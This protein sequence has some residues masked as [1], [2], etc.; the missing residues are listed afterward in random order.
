MKKLILFLVM[1]F[2]IIPVFAGNQ[3][4]AEIDIS[5]YFI[6]LSYF[7][8]AILIVTQFLLKYIKTQ[9]DQLV[10]WVVSFALAGAGWLLELG[11]FIGVEWYWAIIYGAAAGLVANGVFDIPLVKSL[12]G[13][14]QKKKK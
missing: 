3:E 13:V 8:P 12:L 7:I 5:G 2:A 4:P 9:N 11:M 1:I 10:S 6:S 14:I